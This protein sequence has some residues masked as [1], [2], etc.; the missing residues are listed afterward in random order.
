MY[1]VISG[2]SIL[3]VACPIKVSFVSLNF[4][5]VMVSVSDSLVFDIW[6]SRYLN[7]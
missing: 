4:S 7:G 3:N 6:F 2:I 1:I 5:G